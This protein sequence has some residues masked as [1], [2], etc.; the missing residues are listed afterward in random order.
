MEPFM[1]FFGDRN[2]YFLIWGWDGG[3]ECSLVKK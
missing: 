3:I 1:T 2:F